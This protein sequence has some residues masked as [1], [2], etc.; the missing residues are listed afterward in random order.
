MHKRVAD[1]LAD[2]VL[3]ENTG[4]NKKKAAVAFPRVN[5]QTLVLQKPGKH[6]LLPGASLLTGA[7]IEPTL[8]GADG[9]GILAQEEG[10]KN[11]LVHGALSKARYANICRCTP[12]SLM[13]CV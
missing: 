4:L 3:D 13:C 7:R 12:D 10:F 1:Q 9:G 8:G 11:D 2:A 5:M 6:G